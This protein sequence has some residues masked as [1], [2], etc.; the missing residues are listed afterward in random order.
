MV[1][2]P[3]NIEIRVP[4]ELRPVARSLPLMRT[5]GAIALCGFAAVAD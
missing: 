4:D 1:K 2:S 3:E 5:L